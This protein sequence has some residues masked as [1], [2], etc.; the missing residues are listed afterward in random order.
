MANII[1]INSIGLGK[2][3]NAEYTRFMSYTLDNIEIAKRASLGIPTD[4]FDAFRAKIKLLVD[5]ISQS[6]TSDDTASIAEA[7]QLCDDTLRY[8]LGQLE[9]GR[10]SPVEAD[11]TAYTTLYNLTKPYRGI[12]RLPQRQQIQQ[13]EGLLKDLEKP[14]VTDAV[15]RIGLQS[16]IA[17]LKDANQR[18]ASLIQIRANE[19]AAEALPAARG[20]REEID[21]LY[22]PMMSLAF[23]QSVVNGTNEAINFVAA[24]NKLIAD[25]NAAYNLRMGLLK[26]HREKNEEEPKNDSYDEQ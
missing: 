14:A 19:Q 3:N 21:A 1:K 25:T 2:L 4:M 24:Q 23:A 15:V 20:V 22:D 17:A 18:Y 6:R 7:D 5:I 9:R 11:R 8:L 12:N 16:T 13:T 26:S 10:L